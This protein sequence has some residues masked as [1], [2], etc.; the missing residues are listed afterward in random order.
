MVRGS[1][2]VLPFRVRLDVAD[3]LLQR[4]SPE[5]LVPQPRPAPE[6]PGLAYGS[7]ENLIGQY[8]HLLERIVRLSPSLSE[9]QRISL[10]GHALAFE[11]ETLDPLQYHVE[12]LRTVLSDL[13]AKQARKRRRRQRRVKA[14]LSKI[15]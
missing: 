4:R 5:P 8:T 11:H 2:G 7:S 1:N 13:S 10:L 12:R 15:A 14:A 9:N 3:S 6:L